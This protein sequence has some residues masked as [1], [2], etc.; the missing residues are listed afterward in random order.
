M[1]LVLIVGVLLVASFSLITA[2]EEKVA[3]TE[4][5]VN[6]KERTVGLFKPSAGLNYFKPPPCPQNYLF[7]CRP[8]M[9]PVPCRQRPEPSF[10]PQNGN[11]GSYG[12]GARCGSCSMHHMMQ[13]NPV[14]R[15]FY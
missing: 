3:E 12:R 11:Y 1:K 4:E 7:S 13:V 2:E 5:E 15:Q 9:T 10:Y 8:V 14:I 6:E